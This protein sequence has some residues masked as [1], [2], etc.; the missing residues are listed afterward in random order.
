MTNILSKYFEVTVHDGGRGR[1]FHQIYE[2]NMATVHKPQIISTATKG[3]GKGKR[4]ES[5]FTRI[6]FKPDLPRFGYMSSELDTST[7]CLMQRRVLDVSAAL[8]QVSG[9]VT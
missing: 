6:S 2:N 9:G 5:S 7:L 3:G 1:T 4:N 8:G